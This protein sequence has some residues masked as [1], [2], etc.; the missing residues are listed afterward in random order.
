MSA[1]DFS[2]DRIKVLWCAVDNDDSDSI[3]QVEF[4]RFVKLARSDAAKGLGRQSTQGPRSLKKQMTFVGSSALS[5][6]ATS[7]ATQDAH[8][9]Y[10]KKIKRKM[11]TP[12][13]L[14]AEV[15]KA[16]VGIPKGDELKKLAAL[17]NERLDRVVPA[18]Q[19][20]TWFKVFKDFDTDQ[21]GLLMFDEIESGV[22]DRLHIKPSEL[23]EIRLKALWLAMDSDDN[24]YIESSE[25][26]AFMGK[27]EITKIET[28][29]ELLKQKSMKKR[30]QLEAHNKAEIAAEGFVST[31]DTAAMREELAAQGIPPVDDAEKLEMAMLFSGWVQEYMPDRHVGIA[32]LLVFKEMDDDASG[33]LTFDELR[34]VI[35]RKFKISS[36]VFSEE[37]IKS[38][39]CAVDDDN[40]N[41]IALV[42]FGRFIKLATAPAKRR[43]ADSRT[44]YITATPSPRNQ[45]GGVRLPEMMGQFQPTVAR[46]P[47]T[48]GT[49]TA[50]WRNAVDMSKGKFWNTRAWV[51]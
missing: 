19:A 15:K 40:S 37:R 46:R 38:L 12:D 47:T 14:R 16:G 51:R 6:E 48:V 45:T 31:V 26:H 28:R 24:G 18:G 41:S 22:R 5:L 1:K 36:K 23:S 7:K 10:E 44:V 3:A 2:E 25:F 30:E 20:Q 9:A 29:Q 33:L 42:E 17:F 39:W 34:H 49:V 27:P 43:N 13:E 11:V 35:R 32:W 8:V 4:S 50:S 21:S